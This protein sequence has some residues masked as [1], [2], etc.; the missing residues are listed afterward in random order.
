MNVSNLIIMT[1]N[2]LLHFPQETPLSNDN[3]DMVIKYLS[4]SNHLHRDLAKKLIYD[5][6]QHFTVTVCDIREIFSDCKIDL[7]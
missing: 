4:E 2:E 1:I 5:T 3:E 7:T 6:A